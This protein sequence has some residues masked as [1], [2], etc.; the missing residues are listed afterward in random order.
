VKTFFRGNETRRFQFEGFGGVQIAHEIR[1]LHNDKIGMLIRVTEVSASGAVPES[2][3]ELHGHEWK[4][5]F[6]DE[7]R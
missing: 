6:T 4:R 7:V 1:V 5:A 3:F 2:T